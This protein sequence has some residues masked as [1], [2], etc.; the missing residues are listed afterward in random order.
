MKNVIDIGRWPV[1]DEVYLQQQPG[2]VAAAQALGMDPH[3]GSTVFV[4][5]CFAALFTIVLLIL[6]TLTELALKSP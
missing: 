6:L 4:G 1:P 5:I 3:T 2:F